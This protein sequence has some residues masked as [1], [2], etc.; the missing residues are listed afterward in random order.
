MKKTKTFT[1]LSRGRAL[2]C[3]YTYIYILQLSPLSIAPF[4]SCVRM[5]KMWFHKGILK[6]SASALVE[7]SRGLLGQRRSLRLAK[8]LEATRQQCHRCSRLPIA[9]KKAHNPISL[10][11]PTG[12]RN[13]TRARERKK[14]RCVTLREVDSTPARPRTRR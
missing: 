7:P 13:P 1:L 12:G 8:N 5:Y 4:L 11:S 2:V 14:D 6:F 10:P 3:T 9:G